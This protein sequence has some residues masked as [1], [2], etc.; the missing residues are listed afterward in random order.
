MSFNKDKCTWVRA[1]PNINTGWGM[2]GLRVALTRRTWGILVDEK[3]DVSWQC[4]LSAQKDN[5]MLGCMKRSVTSR[6][7][8]MIL[9]FFS[10]LVRPHLEYCIQFWSPPHK[11]NTDL[12]KRGRRWVTKMNRGLE[13]LSCEERLRELGLFRLEKRRL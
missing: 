2:K 5:H 13:H 11:T 6:S 12:L 7:S 8:E 10:G 4:V 1:T 3:L 9:P